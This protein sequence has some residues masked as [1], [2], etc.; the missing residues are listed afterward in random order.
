MIPNLMTVSK[1]RKQLGTSMLRWESSIKNESSNSKDVDWIHL[2]Q[3]RVLVAKF[4]VG[5]HV[6]VD[7]L[8]RQKNTGLTK[9]KMTSQEGFFCMKLFV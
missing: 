5:G 6:S 1:G 4:S 7:S 9:H 2:R 3:D 8:K